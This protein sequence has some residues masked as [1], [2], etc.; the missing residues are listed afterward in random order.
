[1]SNTTEITVPPPIPW[2]YGLRL[3]WHVLTFNDH[4][5]AT[6]RWRMNNALEPQVCEC[7]KPGVVAHE[8]E[9]FRGDAKPIFWHCADHA[10]GEP[11]LS[12]LERMERDL[13]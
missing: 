12:W 2:F 13:A 5:A 8:E 4:A 3:F 10:N 6:L 7:G 1:M 9:G 11:V